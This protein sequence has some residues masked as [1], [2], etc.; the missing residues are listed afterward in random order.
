MKVL[1]DEPR[2]PNW[3]H[4][5]LQA[6]HPGFWKLL[7]GTSGFLPAPR[8][9]GGDVEVDDSDEIV[10][11]VVPEVEFIQE[12]SPV[13][14]RDRPG[15][16]GV[17][18]GRHARA[19][20]FVKLEQLSPAALVVQSKPDLEPFVG[21]EEEV[22]A[23]ET[24]DESAQLDVGNDSILTQRFPTSA[25]PADES[26]D[27]VVVRRRRRRVSVSDEDVSPVPPKTPRLVPPGDADELAQIRAAVS[28]A[29]D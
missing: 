26:D 6:H 4:D 3:F 10:N 27:E 24:V 17:D 19:Q 1:K 5:Y 12:V 8:V 16:S 9:L 13:L 23:D 28:F 18:V 7:C 15:P 14:S 21:A 2:S 20:P 29:T 22:V 25:G 11:V